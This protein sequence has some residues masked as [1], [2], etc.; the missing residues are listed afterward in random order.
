MMKFLHYGFLIL[1]S[2][3]AIWFIR[4]LMKITLSNYHLSIDA[5]ERVIMIR[6]YL[7]LIQEGA[8]Y[9]EKDKKVILDNIFRPTNFGIIKD[10]SSVTV[11]D[12]ISSFKK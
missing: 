12:I 9:D 3:M 8:S 2:S 6:T 11:T 5:N 10:E 1:L 7:S 4:I